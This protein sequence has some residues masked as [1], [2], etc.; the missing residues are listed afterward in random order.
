MCCWAALGPEAIYTVEYCTFEEF[1]LA[2]A[3]SSLRCHDQRS[4]SQHLFH[5]GVKSPSSLTA[6]NRVLCKL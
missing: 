2:S 6:L 1:E 3:V 4:E 5:F